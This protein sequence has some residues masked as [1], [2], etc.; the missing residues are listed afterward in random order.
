MFGGPRTLLTV[1]LIV[2]IV[3]IVAAIA[4]LVVRA[5]LGPPEGDSPYDAFR[6]GSVEITLSL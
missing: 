5:A 1:A 4:T 3:A 2:V 6:A